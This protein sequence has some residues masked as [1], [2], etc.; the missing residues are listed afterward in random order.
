MATPEPT[1]CKCQNV[2]Y[3]RVDH[4]IESNMLIL[5][6][7]QQQQQQEQPTKR[8][9]PVPN[10]IRRRRCLLFLSHCLRSIP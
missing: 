4:V 8:S 7:V 10:S 1:L 6:G 9:A 2:R 5:N 3:T